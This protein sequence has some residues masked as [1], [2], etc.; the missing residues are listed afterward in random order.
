[1]FNWIDFVCFRIPAGVLRRGGQEELPAERTRRSPA[2]P[3]ADSGDPL[4]RVSL[5]SS[6]RGK[7]F[8]DP[9]LGQRAP[10]RRPPPSPIVPT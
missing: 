3:D 7:I 1:M 5:R 9:S 8:G 2:R 10:L 6:A 4:L